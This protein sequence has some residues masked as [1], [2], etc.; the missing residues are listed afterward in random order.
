[1]PL[2]T[3]DI[4]KRKVI[5]GGIPLTG[6]GEKQMEV[7][8][9]EDSFTEKVGL[10]GHTTHVLNYNQNAK[11]TVYLMESSASN[12]ALSLIAKNDR[13]SGTGALPFLV[14]D[15]SG[16]TIIT[17]AK[18][19]ITKM[20]KVEFGKEAGE[21]AWIFTLVDADIFVGGNN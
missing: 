21:R 1:M 16:R 12:D 8:Y 19:R 9:N 15:L 17:A 11:A 14:T 2:T 13:I 18:A 20:P 4:R 3:I 7:E 5:F 10:D 6:F